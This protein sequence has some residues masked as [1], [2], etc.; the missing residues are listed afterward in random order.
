M[1]CHTIHAI[2]IPIQK[3]N[4]SLGKGKARTTA[5]VAPGK[6]TEH[7]VRRL[8]HLFANEGWLGGVLRT[9]VW[10]IENPEAPL[11]GEHLHNLLLATLALKRNQKQGQE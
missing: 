5:A 9:L 11:V 8:A 7:Q 6:S 4:K 1:P 10:R 2:V 3:N